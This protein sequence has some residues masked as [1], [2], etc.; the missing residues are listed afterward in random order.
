MENITGHAAFSVEDEVFETVQLDGQ[1]FQHGGQPAQ[2][3]TDQ[4]RLVY[5]VLLHPVS[6][7]SLS[8][9]KMLIFKVI[10]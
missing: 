6:R 7:R 8:K 1:T 4:N 10:S 5:S 9:H 2:A 3:C